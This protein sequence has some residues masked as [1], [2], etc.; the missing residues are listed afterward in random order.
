ML[1]MKVC[2]FTLTYIFFTSYFLVSGTT[3]TNLIFLESLWLFWKEM[4]RRQEIRK[5]L[6]QWNKDRDNLIVIHLSNT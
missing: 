3:I 2:T 4:K 5:L 6:T 1:P